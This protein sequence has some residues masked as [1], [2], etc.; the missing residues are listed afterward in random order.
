MHVVILHK[1]E[2]PKTATFT[3]PPDILDPKCK[4]PQ[5]DTGGSYELFYLHDSKSVK[6]RNQTLNG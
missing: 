1:V 3:I 4:A 2:Q 6:S 5:C